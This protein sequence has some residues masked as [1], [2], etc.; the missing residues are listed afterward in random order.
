MDIPGTT[1]SSLKVCRCCGKIWASE[2]FFFEIKAAHTTAGN[3]ANKKNDLMEQAG[4]DMD[5]LTS[6]G[7]LP[8]F[9]A[10]FCFDNDHPLG[11][12]HGARAEATG[13]YAAANSSRLP[14]ELAAFVS[15][16]VPRTR[17]VT[18]LPEV[19]TM[20]RKSLQRATKSHVAGHLAAWWK[21]DE[22][23]EWLRTKQAIYHDE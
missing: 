13:A 18:P 14:P 17:Y 19:V 16:L 22:G 10:N 3:I 7:C 8:S 21:S 1:C 11:P 9:S 2:L 12:V 5:W 15:S 20:T 6:T 4:R 23:K